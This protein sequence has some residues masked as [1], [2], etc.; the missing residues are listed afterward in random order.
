MSERR[1]KFFASISGKSRQGVELFRL[2]GRVDEDLG[3][4][5]AA[6][7]LTVEPWQGEQLLIE[8]TYQELT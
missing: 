2:N 5:L 3:N 8:V 6:A 4:A 7:L 1:K